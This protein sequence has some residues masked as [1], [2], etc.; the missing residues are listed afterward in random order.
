MSVVLPSTDVLTVTEFSARIARA[1]RTVGGGV[2]EGEALKPTVTDKGMLFFALT[3]GTAELTCKVFPTQVR[4]LEH[5]PRHGDLVQVRIDRPDLWTKA[6]RLNV[7]VSEV[8]LAGEGEL[9]RRREDLLRRLTAA[10]MCDPERRKPRPRFPRAVGVIAGKDSA[11]LRDVV[12]ALQDRFPP[13]HIVT[14]PAMVQGAR[15][16]RDIIDALATLDSHPLVDVI[17]IARGGGSVQDL[18][19]FDNEELCRAVFACGTPVIAAVG[20]T[21]NVP[22]CNHVAWASQTPS[23]S[24][25]L[26]VPSADTLRRDLA[27]AGSRLAP[28]PSRLTDLAQKVAGLRVDVG[29]AVRSRRLE[30]ARVAGELRDAE[31]EFFDTRTAALARAREMLAGLPGRLPKAADIAALAARL[32]SRAVRFFSDRAEQVRGLAN[33]RAPVDAALTAHVHAVRE[34]AGE[35]RRAAPTLDARADAVTSAAPTTSAVIAVL[36]ARRL[37]AEEHGRRVGVGIHKELADHLHDYGR[38][39]PKRA[40]A[41]RDASNR[42]FQRG[43][44][45]VDATGART[46]EGAHRRVADAR[47]A[48]NHASELLAVSDPRRRGWVLPTDGG[49]VVVRSVARLA[50][51]DRLTLSFH[52][53]T[54]GAVI[55]DISNREDS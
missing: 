36:D 13:V 45:R 11:G 5:H 35:L 52:D 31:H 1:L 41:I 14:R 42:L 33:F 12:R 7:I 15:A 50:L 22:V 4:G 53:G 24:P 40:A 47:R 17:V 51:G 23:R 43:R 21:D 39:L 8:R 20:H 16:P 6:G 9:L 30:V 29:R 34:A 28:L 26:A 55:D 32:D 54:A 25:E 2:V 48:L 3:D 18:L 27:L 19:A 37:G 49:G 38:A 44:E 10:G 46:A